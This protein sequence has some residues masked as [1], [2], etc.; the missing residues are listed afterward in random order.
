MPFITVTAESAQ[1]DARRADSEIGRHWWRGFLH[2]I[3]V[4]LKDLID[5]AGVRATA[6]S[7]LFKDRIPQEDKSP[8]IQK[9]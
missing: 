5:T 2:S 7:A 8:T 1:A 9:K 6:A 3:P 4:G